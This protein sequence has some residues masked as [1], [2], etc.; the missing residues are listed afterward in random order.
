V[1]ES[2]CGE[3][4]TAGNSDCPG[5]SARVPS[6]ASM[7]RDGILRTPLGI[8]VLETDLTLSRHIE[9][10]GRLDTGLDEISVIAQYIPEG[11]VVVNAGAALGD[12]ACVYSQLVGARGHV[13]AYEPHPLYY[14]ALAL[15]MA[16][17]TNVTTYNLALGR[18][19]GD[20]GLFEAPDRGCSAIL[21]ANT[22]TAVAKQRDGSALPMPRIPVRVVR[23]D[24]HLLPHLTRCDFLHFD[25]EGFEP[26]I[27]M[28]APALLERFRPVL[29]LEIG[30]VHL[31]RWQMTPQ[32]VI[33]LLH[34]L[35]YETQRLNCVSAGIEG[36]DVFNVLCRP[37]P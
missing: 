1:K 11:G 32:D 24:D 2:A 10:T 36:I 5:L 3:G 35:R 8:Y 15:N 23:L 12:H 18:D 33:A 9:L 7:S 22:L 14:D 4:L 31:S 6:P 26:Q 27:L 21:P 30:D 28:G 16:R 17:F 20:A 34:D 37:R 19:A 29:L 25:A 13:Y